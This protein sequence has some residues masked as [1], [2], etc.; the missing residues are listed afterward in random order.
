LENDS[1]YDTLSAP[2]FA[3]TKEQNES[4]C[5]V[6]V[7]FSGWARRTLVK[8]DYDDVVVLDVASRKKNVKQKLK[9]SS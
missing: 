2:L 4:G 5:D 6:F 1:F 3:H 9:L 8:I 7:R